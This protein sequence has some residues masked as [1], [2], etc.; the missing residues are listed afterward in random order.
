M[1]RRRFLLSCSAAAALPGVALAQAPGWP[2][3]PLRLVIGYPPGG[4]TDIA[5]RLLAERLGRSLGQQVIVDNRAGAGGTVGAMSVVRAEPDGYTLLLAASPEVSIAPITMKAL[6]YDPVRDLQPITLVGQVPF[7]LVVNPQ[8]PART[9]EEFI[10]YAR[11]NPGKLNY[12]SFGNNT[13]NHLAGELFKSMARINSVHVPY[14]GS[15]PSITDLIGGQIQYSFDTP[16]AVLEQVKAG[17]LRAL[18]V[19]GRQ[20]LANAPDV[21]TF[22]EAGLP[23]FTGGT[24]FGLLA[25]A[26]TPRAV[27]ERV[28]TEAVALLAAPELSR[29]FAERDIVPAGQSPEEFGRFIQSEVAKWKDLAAKVG[30]VAE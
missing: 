9:L 25:P 18:A 6:A 8:L 17:K 12:S 2:A 24:W 28:N 15:G 26:K 30:I 27:I 21:P 11:A 5:G 14:K 29:A 20:R 16:T 4:S 19:A 10:A 7:F 1:Q 13:S 23:G 22:A 3:R